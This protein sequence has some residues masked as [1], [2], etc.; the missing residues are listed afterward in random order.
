MDR[1]WIVLIAICIT[2]SLLIPQINVHTFG[3][4][5][6]TGFSD[7]YRYYNA[8]QNGSTGDRPAVLLLYPFTVA[9][10]ELFH[11]ITT[12]MIYLLIGW[13]FYSHTKDKLITILALLCFSTTLLTSTA[14]YAQAIVIIAGL[15][16]WI[17]CPVEATVKSLFKWFLFAVLAL[18]S[19]PLGILLVIV[20]MLGKS[21]WYKHLI[22]YDG[23][24]LYSE[25]IRLLFILIYISSMFI[26][27][28]TSR[29]TA[30]NFFYPTIAPINLGAFNN[31]LWAVFLSLP[32]VVLFYGSGSDGAILVGCLLMIG[33]T[34]SLLLGGLEVNFWRCLI[35]FDWIALLEIAKAKRTPVITA[36]LVFLILFGLARIPLGL[37]L[38]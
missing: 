19:H 14:I 20:L 13:L 30:V 16:A 23:R 32:L 33:A 27:L 18:F 37:K 5:S 35:I 34:T 4:S 9:G 1:F 6:P 28:T 12:L 21:E 3:V 10:I 11:I 29:I 26:L 31:I 22:Q 17:Y 24:H 36:A 25:L 2:L 7:E 15:Y 38:F 8:I